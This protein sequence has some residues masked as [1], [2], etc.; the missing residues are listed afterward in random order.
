MKRVD[1]TRL[2]DRYLDAL[3]R[4]DDASPVDLDPTLVATARRIGESALLPG[5]DLPFAARLWSELRTQKSV[6]ALVASDQRDALG[7][8]KVRSGVAR[9][10]R[11]AWSSRPLAE[12]ATALLLILALVGSIVAFRPQGMAPAATDAG[13][14]TYDL[15][16]ATDQYGRGLGPLDPVT[17]DDAAPGPTFDA[18][19]VGLN[20]G[21]AVEWIGSTDGS[22]VVAIAQLSNNGLA[23]SPDEVTIVVWD[24]RTGAERARFHP[25]TG[26][27]YSPRLSRD[28][29]RLVLRG[30]V[31]DTGEPLGPGESVWYVHDTADGR[32]L[33]MQPEDTGWG[34]F[35]ID[36]TATRVYQLIGDAAVHPTGPQPM[37]FT[38]SDLTTGDE[39]AQLELASVLGG[40]WPTEKERGGLPVMGRLSPGLAISPDG[41]T[42]AVVHANREAVT[43]I[44][45][46]RLVVERTVDLAR[47][48]SW[49]DRLR[50][51]VPLALQSAEAKQAEEGTWIGATFGGD[52]RYLYVTG[53]ETEFGDGNRP[54]FLDLGIRVVNL[55][56]G[57]I[58]AEL[59]P[60]SAV[61]WVLPAPDSRS[62]Y[63]FGPM[64]QNNRTKGF[65]LRRL[66][67]AT[68]DPLA[69]RPFSPWRSAFLVM[70]IALPAPPVG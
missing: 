7:G 10:I 69:E 52:G 26:I 43:L 65:I 42:I 13:P 24:A 70:P 68:L 19:P 39:I 12:V 28:G 27:V 14:L 40:T 15:Y 8:T 20:Q 21:G 17:L 9:G 18:P 25:T 53:S 49:R 55:E 61:D 66:D 63:V 1:P 38:V 56:Q 47:P 62:V 6:T 3:S 41:R 30:E 23:T 31:F 16:A 58:I 5:P 22:T 51:L 37:H 36:P 64:D 11:T 2:L 45:A 60:G 4:G 57:S 32:L 50:D 35:A 33:A 46:E 44:D 67:A 48:R 54:T 29:S 59:P 34:P